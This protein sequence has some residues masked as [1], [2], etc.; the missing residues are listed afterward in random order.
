ML[1]R[2]ALRLLKEWKQTKVREGLL[3]TG[4]RQVG[5]TWLIERFA[6]ALLLPQQEAW[7]TGLLDP[8]SRGHDIAF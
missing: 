6:E 3:V 4:A 1:E 2:K 7:R 5:K 8:D